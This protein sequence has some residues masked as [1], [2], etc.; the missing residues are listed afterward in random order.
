MHAQ[1]RVIPIKSYR[2]QNFRKLEYYS[3]LRLK[4]SLSQDMLKEMKIFITKSKTYNVQPSGRY[5]RNKI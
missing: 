1:L 2:N 5:D 4:S 3:I